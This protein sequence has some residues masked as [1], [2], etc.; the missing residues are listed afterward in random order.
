M[1]YN[2]NV[3]Y[4]IYPNKLKIKSTSPKAMV[5]PGFLPESL[6]KIQL[7]LLILSNAFYKIRIHSIKFYC[8]LINCSKVLNSEALLKHIF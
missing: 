7:I 1:L 8:R 2:H 4:T 6:E 3:I 5:F